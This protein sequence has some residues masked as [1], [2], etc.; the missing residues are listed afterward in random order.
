M[1]I[2]GTGSSGLMHLVELIDNAVDEAAAGFAKQV[3]LLFTETGL[4]KWQIMVAVFY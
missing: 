1:Y 3:R 2:G 4:L